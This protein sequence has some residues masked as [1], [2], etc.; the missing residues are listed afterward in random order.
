MLA[1]ESKEIV[2]TER[3]YIHVSCRTFETWRNANENQHRER[4]LD[5]AAAKS[6][7]AEDKTKYVRPTLSSLFLVLYTASFE[8]WGRSCRVVM[9]R[10]AGSYVQRLTNCV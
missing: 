5:A 2:C 9:A 10:H 6:R 1:S 8:D 7:V 4:N 3:M